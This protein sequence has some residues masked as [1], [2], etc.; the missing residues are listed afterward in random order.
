MAWMSAVRTPHI[1]PALSL[2]HIQAFGSPPRTAISKRI[3][4]RGTTAEYL[5]LAVIVR[6][7]GSVSANNPHTGINRGRRDE[8]YCNIRP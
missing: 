6:I 2:F 7:W 8:I 5:E 1:P 4:A 3:E